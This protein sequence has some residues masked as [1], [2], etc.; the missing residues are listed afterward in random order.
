MA[1]VT[2][3]EIAETPEKIESVEEIAVDSPS[4]PHESP[5]V[6]RA[7]EKELRAQEL[8]LQAPPEPVKRPRGRPKGAPNKPK[9]PAPVPAK[10]K[11]QAKRPPSS[12]S[13]SSS[14]E[15]P[16]PRQGKRAAVQDLMEDDLETQVLKFLS[17]R[18]TSQQ[19][20][21]RQLWQNLATA[22]LGR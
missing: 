15:E 7:P 20:Q 5:P 17:A 2:M 22:G 11:K 3:E 12:S 18:R 8:V 14:E 19:Q 16:A 9:A 4:E 1:R 6:E 10:P 21:R 13:D